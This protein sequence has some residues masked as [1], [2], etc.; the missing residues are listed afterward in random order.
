MASGVVY[1]GDRLERHRLGIAEA[2]I[3]AQLQ[4]GLGPSDD[5]PE[6]VR[7][8]T[9]RKQRLFAEDSRFIFDLRTQ[10]H[11]ERVHVMAASGLAR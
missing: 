1:G 2:E 5:V 8:L 4:R 9:E 6:F 3:T 10:Q 11:G 7:E